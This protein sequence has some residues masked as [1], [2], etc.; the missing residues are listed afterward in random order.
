M[1]SLSNH[2]SFDRLSEYPRGGFGVRRADR[3]SG[4]QPP[5]QFR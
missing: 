1:V 4:F 2:L 5:G 3:T